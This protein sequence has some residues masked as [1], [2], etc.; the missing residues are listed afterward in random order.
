MPA[1][2]IGELRLNPPSFFGETPSIIIEML[3]RNGWHVAWMGVEG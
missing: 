2:A 1:M 3:Q